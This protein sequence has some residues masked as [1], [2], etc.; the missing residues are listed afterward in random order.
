M[1]GKLARLAC[2]VTA[3]AG[4]TLAGGLS[5]SAAARPSVGMGEEVVLTYYNNAQ[6]T[7]VMGGYS[8]GCTFSSWGSTSSYYTTNEY[9]C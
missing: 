3:A 4:L 1:A 8:F 2:A 6:H 5:A 7:T 9:A